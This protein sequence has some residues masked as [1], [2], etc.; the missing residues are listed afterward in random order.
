MT[1]DLLY[2]AIASDRP[3]HLFSIPPTPQESGART[4]WHHFDATSTQRALIHRGLSALPSSSPII[5]RAWRGARLRSSVTGGGLSGDNYERDYRPAIKGK[6]VDAP[7][8][9]SVGVEGL[10]FWLPEDRWVAEMRPLVT[11]GFVIGGFSRSRCGRWLGP[12]VLVPP[13][14]TYL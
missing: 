14:L 9:S 4:L 11:F 13:F 2:T 1:V 7:V 6:G 8:P 3:T 5:P 10:R 12:L